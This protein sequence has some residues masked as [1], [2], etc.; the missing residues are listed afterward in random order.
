MKRLILLLFIF[1]SVSLSFSQSGY[2]VKLIENVDPFPSDNKDN[3]SALWGY[4]APDGREYAILGCYFGTAFIDIT[5]SNNISMI[6]FLPSPLGTGSDWRE[7]KTYSHYA[8]I[9]SESSESRNR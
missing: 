3:Y 6:Y 2:R 9:V 7:M 4:T 1:T 5:D 8:Y